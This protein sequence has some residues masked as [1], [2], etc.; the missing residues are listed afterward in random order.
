MEGTHWI[1]GNSLGHDRRIDKSKGCV[2]KRG[3]C[4]NATC[5]SIGMERSCVSYSGCS[6]CSQAG[7]KI[8]ELI[9]ALLSITKTTQTPLRMVSLLD[10]A[11]SVL[12]RLKNLSDCPS[13]RLSQDLKV[14]H[15]PRIIKPFPIESLSG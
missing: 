12:I 7:D 13:H 1:N 2:E 8:L 10:V 6:F 5:T 15:F 9:S 3:P 11:V 4:T 14:G